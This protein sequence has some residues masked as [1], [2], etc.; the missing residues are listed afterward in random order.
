MNR[1]AFQN[2]EKGIVINVDLRNGFK[3][4][5]ENWLRTQQEDIYWDIEFHEGGKIRLVP[6]VDGFQLEFVGD[7]GVFILEQEDVVNV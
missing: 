2:K 3:D 1:V 4:R 7:N 6:T 5:L